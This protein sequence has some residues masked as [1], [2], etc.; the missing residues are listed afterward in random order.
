MK[1]R[2]TQNQ[3]EKLILATQ[4]AKNPKCHGKRVAISNFLGTLP[5]HTSF[6]DDY[7]NLQMDARLY[8]WNAQTQSAILKGLNLSHYGK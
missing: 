2:L 4:K 5:A 6:G 1:T 7:A 8:G 3:I